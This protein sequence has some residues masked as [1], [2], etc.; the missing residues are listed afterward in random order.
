VIVSTETNPVVTAR[1]RK[2]GIEAEVAVAD[3][4]AAVRRILEARG[5]GRGDAVYIGNDVNDLPAASEVDWVV[6]PADAHPDFRAVAS[7]VTV[8]RGGEGV[9]R[10]L[11]DLTARSEVPWR[12]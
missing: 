4:G 12:F 3:K 11:V 1:A 5:L 8:A 7:H 9:L 2:L 6:A 10:E